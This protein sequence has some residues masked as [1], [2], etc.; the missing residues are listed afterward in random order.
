M[1]E[2]FKEKIKK[3]KESIDEIEKRL[4][5]TNFPFTD[6]PEFLET[7]WG[8]ERE[9]IRPHPTINGKH[10][11]YPFEKY[12]QLREEEKEEKEKLAIE[13]EETKKVLDYLEKELIKAKAD[14]V[15]VTDGEAEETEGKAKRLKLRPIDNEKLNEDIVN[16]VQDF[17]YSGE[18][19]MEESF[20]KLSKNSK[21]IFGIELT[22][23]Q[24]EGRFNRN[25]KKYS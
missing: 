5:K 19:S 4:K 1:S 6:N 10:I 23:S 15:I 12:L 18:G 3:L 14:E 24:I 17:V 25:K 20:Q 13:V 21:E 7:R 8:I 2:I 22:K 16:N 9:I 11:T